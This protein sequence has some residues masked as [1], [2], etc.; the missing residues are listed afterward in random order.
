MT[1]WNCSGR[2]GAKPC[3]L[4][5]VGVVRGLGGSESA[6]P[7]QC[8][9]LCN[10]R[11]T[12]T[13]VWSFGQAGCGRQAGRHADV[14]AGER[15]GEPWAS[16][17]AR[18]VFTIAVANRPANVPSNHFFIRKTTSLL[19]RQNKNEFHWNS[20]YK[21]VCL[22]QTYYVMNVYVC[23]LRCF[24]LGRAGGRQVAGARVAG[25]QASRGRSV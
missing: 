2:R 3:K 5:M 18:D 20:P 14:G 25:G 12:V 9:E 10:H 15:A 6:V 1:I 13:V 8:Q 11:I 4:A 23:F 17:H 22:C 7:L 21:H 24:K 19:Q 16:H